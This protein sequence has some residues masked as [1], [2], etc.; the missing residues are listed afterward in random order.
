[1]EFS[2]D[3]FETHDMVK[4]LTKA[5]DGFITEK[6]NFDFKILGHFQQ[7]WCCYGTV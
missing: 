2:G 4:T 5:N 3:K 1:M 6:I 7:Y